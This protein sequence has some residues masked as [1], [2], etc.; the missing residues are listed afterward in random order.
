[1]KPLFTI[2]LVLFFA[3]STVAAQD[4]PGVESLTSSKSLFASKKAAVGGASLSILASDLTRDQKMTCLLTRGRHAVLPAQADDPLSSIIDQ[5]WVDE[6][7]LN[8]FL[9]EFGYEE[10]LLTTIFSFIWNPDTEGWDPEGETTFTFD[11][12]EGISE[13]I[14]QSFEGEALVNALRIRIQEDEFANVLLFQQDFFE[15][16]EW[17][18]GLLQESIVENG[19]IVETVTQAMDDSTGI[20]TNFLLQQFEYDDQQRVIVEY[21]NPWNAEVE[22]F[23]EF[24][25]IVTEYFENS[26]VETAQF[27]TGP[28]EW[29]DFDQTTRNYNERGLLIEEINVQVFTGTPDPQSRFVLDYNDLDL[30]ISEIGQS[31]DGVGGWVNSTGFFSTYDDDGDVLE[32]LFQSWIEPGKRAGGS[33]VSSIASLTWANDFRSIFNYGDVGTGVED[34]AF[35]SAVAFDLYPNPARGRVS[36]DVSLEKSSV[37]RVEVFDLLGRRVATLVD[38]T[39]PAGVQKLVWET[40]QM[41]AGLYLVRFNVDESVETRA[42]TLVR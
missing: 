14:V 40:R 20:L 3:A 28:E 27:S 6:A 7:W 11:E 5:I 30:L 22:A 18:T 17:Q 9:A 15:N 31:P 33:N 41:P 16:E 21:Q 19:L 23:E 29:L 8:D 39:S 25:R 10:D 42:V 2:L 35:S 12:V 4:C 36:F 32:E 26:D 34:D 1:M 37:L 24:L 38:E 13:I